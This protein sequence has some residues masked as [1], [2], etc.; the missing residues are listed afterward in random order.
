MKPCKFLAQ[1]YC[2]NGNSCAFSHEGNP[3]TQT[4]FERPGS[5]LPD[6]Q[7]LN[8]DPVIATYNDTGIKPSQIC[9]FFLQGSCNYGVKCRNLHSPAVEPHSQVQLDT[10]SLEAHLGQQV[11][12][13]LHRPLDS[14]ARVTCSFFS[15]P[16]GCQRS[17]C[18]YLHVVRDLDGQPSNQN[19][20]ADEDEASHQLS[21]RCDQY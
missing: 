20:K 21:H 14:R 10:V 9:R 18:P 3:S 13:S 5:A 4:N 19:S 17:S 7:M 16:G 12:N 11:T 15:K 2:R 8:L 1:G 6:T